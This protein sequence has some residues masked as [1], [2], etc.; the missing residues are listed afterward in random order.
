MK[1]NNGL[2]FSK[3][4][5]SY[6]GTENLETQKERAAFYQYDIGLSK[7]M[8]ERQSARDMFGGEFNSDTSGV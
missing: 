7:E 5:I 6:F 2:I 1:I 3:N 8:S 4:P